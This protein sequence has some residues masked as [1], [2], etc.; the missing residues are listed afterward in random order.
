M[1]TKV[2]IWLFQGILGCSSRVCEG[3]SPGGVSEPPALLLTIGAAVGPAVHC[4]ATDDQQQHAQSPQFTTTVRSLCTL[5]EGAHLTHSCVTAPW[6]SSMCT[7]H[8][9]QCEHCTH[10]CIH[11]LCCAYMVCTSSCFMCAVF[12]SYDMCTCT[13]VHKWLCTFHTYDCAVHNAHILCRAGAAAA[14]PGWMA[15][16]PSGFHKLSCH[17]KPF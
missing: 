8:Y 7:V 14:S 2:Y 3:I 4:D 9:A 15:G 10:C 6:T 17:L 13:I 12:V 5:G 16:G 1:C 11:I